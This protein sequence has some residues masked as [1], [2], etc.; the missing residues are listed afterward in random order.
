[1]A[2]KRAAQIGDCGTAI[3]VFT[4]K[5]HSHGFPLQKKGGSLNP[6]PIHLDRKR[7]DIAGENAVIL[8]IVNQLLNAKHFMNANAL[9]EAV[10]TGVRG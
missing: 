7:A 10:I 4:D 1:M 6:R 8:V 2:F 3:C 9:N 5:F